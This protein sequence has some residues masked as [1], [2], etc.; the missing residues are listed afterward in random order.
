MP[1]T[2]ELPLHGGHVPRWMLHYMK[3][4][5]KAIVAYIVEVKGPNALIEGLS[6]PVW[7]QAFNNVVGMDWDSSGS[8]TV[9]TG[10]LR[11]ISRE[12]DYGFIVLGGK[13]KAMREVPEEAMLA[14]RLGVDPNAVV[15]FSKIAARIDSSFIQDGYNLYH[16]AV[17]VGEKDKIL[18]VQ[19]GMNTER[20]LARRYHLTRQDLEKPHSGVAGI[21]GRTILNATGPENREARKVYLDIIAE[22]PKRFERL[23]WEAYRKARGARSLDYYIV[24]NVQDV[25]RRPTYTY[26]PVRPERRLIK[27]MEE[28]YKF[29]PT[30]DVELA[31]A[32]K[33]GPV[34]LRALALIADL[35]YS[36]P[37]SDKDPVTHPLNPYL[38][39][40]A[41]GGKDGVPRSFDPKTAAMAARLIEEAI[42]SAK[43]G[44]R[45]KMKALE[46]L[47]LFL[48]ARLGVEP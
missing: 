7:F 39:A 30:N 8:T 12:E 40:Y 41:V 19:Q 27:A 25:T 4:L 21:P 43:L 16:H 6:D 42:E 38:Y 31:L 47:R 3:R 35:V 24:G 29:N 36:V 14:E 46:R 22:G 37:T 10:I 13:G 17:F 34:L 32:P 5:A 44:S 20:R 2:A 26:K 45:E 33:L 1:G 23:L 15:R 18:V 48:R 11:E 28:V 9:L